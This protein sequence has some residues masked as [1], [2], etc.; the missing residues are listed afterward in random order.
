MEES[1]YQR[2]IAARKRLQDI[3]E[4]LLDPN[5]MKDLKHFRDISKERAALAEQVEVFDR[6]QKNEKG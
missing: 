4:E 5:T 6:Y 2:L 1:M 3:D